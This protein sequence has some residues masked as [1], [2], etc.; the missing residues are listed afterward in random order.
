MSIV[1]DDLRQHAAETA[2]PGCLAQ[3]DLPVHSAFFSCSQVVA[4]LALL[5]ALKDS[6]GQW[7]RFELRSE[8][9]MCE[10]TLIK[11]S[12]IWPVAEY[13]RREYDLSCRISSISC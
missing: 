9:A 7:R 6:C 10:E 11:Q 2:L 3:A 1:R 4:G 13:L 12:K 5:V 8:Q